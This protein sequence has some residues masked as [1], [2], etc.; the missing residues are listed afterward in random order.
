MESA[1]FITLEATV[2][3]AVLILFDVKK[4]M[5]RKVSTTMLVTL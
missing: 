4:T 2:A 3:L 5:K 1:P